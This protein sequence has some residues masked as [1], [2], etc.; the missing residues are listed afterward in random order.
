MANTPAY[1]QE[2]IAK[3]MGCTVEQLRSQHAKNATQ[4]ALMLHKAVTSGRKVNGYT[5]DQ[6][7]EMHLK[8]HKR[9]YPCAS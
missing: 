5:A 3:V 8:A 7:R 4:L 2:M 6:L 9:A 1:T